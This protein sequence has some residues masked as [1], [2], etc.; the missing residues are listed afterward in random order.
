MDTMAGKRDMV[1]I[2]MLRFFLTSASN[3]S[4]SY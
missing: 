3:E 1:I 2:W 4:S